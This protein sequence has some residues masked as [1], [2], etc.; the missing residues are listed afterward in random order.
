MQPGIR[1]IFRG[2]KSFALLALGLCE[3][4]RGSLLFFILPIYAR[5]VLGLSE[6]VIGY[7][8]AAHYLLDTGLRA[9]AGHFVDRFGGRNVLLIALAFAFGGLVTVTKSHH[10]IG[11]ILGC[12]ALGV[13][14]ASI[15]P[16]TISRVTQGLG[17]DA[18]AT[19]MGGV[20]MAWLL[21]VGG[22]AVVTSWIFSNHVQGGFATLL[23]LW[24]LAYALVI[25]IMGGRA[26]YQATV[27]I[28]HG[29]RLLLRDILDVRLLFPGMFVQT[30][31]MGLLLPVL[32]LYARYILDLDGRMYSY[33]LVAGGS[34]TVLLQV[35]MGRLVD[36]YGYKHFL[37][38]GFVLAALMLAVILRMHNLT[39][40]FLS[41]GGLGAG[42]ALILPSW[43]AV[44]A[45]SVPEQQRAGMFGVFMTV[46]GLGMAI[47]PLVGMS[48]WNRLGPE[49]PFYGAAVILLV[50]S[51]FYS[52]VRLDRVFL[53]TQN[54]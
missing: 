46:E 33:L 54:G 22:G 51:V 15:W 42:Y 1:D 28:R 25:I 45:R 26:K 37:S 31:A 21:G 19:A 30:F 36:K 48:L 44:L 13:G 20:M 52:F 17:E 16:A 10:P 32:A 39:Y 29:I 4:V 3:F 14:M 41:V 27:K 18:Y 38:P 2:A 11:I 49:A 47:G 40:V 35:P 7:A 6:E 5:G 50:M 12:A 23:A 9:L 8:I 43:N 53:H 24:I 34:A